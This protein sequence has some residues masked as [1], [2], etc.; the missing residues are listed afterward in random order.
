MGPRRPRASSRSC[1]G[2]K[3]LRLPDLGLDDEWALDEHTREIGKV[4]AARAKALLMACRSGAGHAFSHHAAVEEAGLFAQLTAAGEAVE[5]VALLV[6][7]HRRITADLTTGTSSPQWL[8]G[9][10]AELTLHAEIEDN[11]LFPYAMQMLPN[12]R[13]GLVEEIHQ[14]LLTA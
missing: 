4:A 2:T 6:A 12:D 11:D 9:V 13:W 7:Q 10:L 5:E 8:R 3:Q 14:L 1:Q